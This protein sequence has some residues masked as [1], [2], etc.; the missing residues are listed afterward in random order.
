MI[1][2]GK[3]AKI[4]FVKDNTVRAPTIKGG[5]VKVPDGLPKDSRT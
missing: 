4:S 2:K 5:V 3:K 1:K